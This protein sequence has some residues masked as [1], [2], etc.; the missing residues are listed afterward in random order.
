MSRNIIEVSY[1][2]CEVLSE[3]KYWIAGD[4]CKSIKLTTYNGE[5]ASQDWVVIELIDDKII[6]IIKRE[7]ILK[8]SEQL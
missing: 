1:P 8:Y 3:R 2:H 7:C 5:M 4:N 6:E